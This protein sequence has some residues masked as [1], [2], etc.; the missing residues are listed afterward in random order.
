L[1]RAFETEPWTRPARVGAW[2]GFDRSDEIADAAAAGDVLELEERAG[3]GHSVSARSSVGMLGETALH[4]AA[5]AG[6]AEAVLTLVG[7]LGAQVNLKSFTGRTALH[8]AA[9]H[10]RTEAVQALLELGAEQGAR[11]EDGLSA[12]DLALLAGAHEVVRLL[13]T[14]HRRLHDKQLEP[15]KGLPPGNMYRQRMG[16][17]GVRGGAKGISGDM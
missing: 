2:E 13:D 17:T 1:A 4:A 16:N 11:D 5:R 7:G 3:R 12:I 15:S 9:A 14:K 8:V 6:H 10:G